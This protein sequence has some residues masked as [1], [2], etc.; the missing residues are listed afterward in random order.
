LEQRHND[1]LDDWYDVALGKKEGHIYNRN[2]NPTFGAFERKVAALEGAERAISFASGMAAISNT[3]LSL[4]KPGDRVVSIKDSYGGT[5]LM[6]LEFLPKF[7]IEVVLCET[8]DHGEIEAEVAKGCA[9]L[10]LET[11]TNPTLKIIDLD[12]TNEF[13]KTQWRRRESAKAVAP[14]GD[15]QNMQA[16]K[17]ALLDKFGEA[18]NI[19]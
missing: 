13:I 14:P 7:G 5:S 1:N 9:L 10:H 19:K 18:R 3:L 2:T 11:P 4:L 15:N 12:T 17:A 8:S 6:F 16:L